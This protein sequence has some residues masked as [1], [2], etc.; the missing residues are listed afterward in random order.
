MTEKVDK[1]LKSALLGVFL[2]L[3]DKYVVQVIKRESG[4]SL[5]PRGKLK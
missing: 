3:R 4:Q 2:G 1:N 5:I